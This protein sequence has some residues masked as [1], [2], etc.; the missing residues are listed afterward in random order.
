MRCRVDFAWVLAACLSVLCVPGR[1]R[2]RKL[3]CQTVR[4]IRRS[5]PA[6]GGASCLQAPAEMSENGMFASS[7]ATQVAASPPVGLA[8]GGQAG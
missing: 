5:W 8:G 1:N 3:C 6:G 2:N 4:R 7:A